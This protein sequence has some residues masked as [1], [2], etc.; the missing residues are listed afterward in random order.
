MKIK[1]YC[2]NCGQEYD[3]EGE[4][5]WIQT[6]EKMMCQKCRY[7]GYFVRKRPRIE[8]DQDER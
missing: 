3:Y 8:K 7:N 4:H 2:P 1:V 6:K 5:G